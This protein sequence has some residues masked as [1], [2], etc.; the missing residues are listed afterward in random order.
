MYGH[1]FT[2]FSIPNPFDAPKG[3]EE[4]PF[5]HGP[6]TGDRIEHRCL[7]TLAPKLFVIGHGKPVRLVSDPLEQMKW[8]GVVLEEKRFGKLWNQNPKKHISLSSRPARHTTGQ[9]VAG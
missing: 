8:P 4:A 2:R 1:K 5:E 9:W 7:E 3:G 6:D